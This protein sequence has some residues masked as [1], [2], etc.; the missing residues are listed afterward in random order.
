MGIKGRPVLVSDGIIS[1]DDRKHGGAATSVWLPAGEVYVTPAGGSAEGVIVADHLFYQGQ[2]I[3]GLKLEI[4]GGKMVS[5]TAKSGLESLKSLYDAAGEGKDLVGVI[6]L[7]INS[8]IHVPE[9]SPVNVW[10]R[11][12][13]VTV[14]VGNNTWAGGDNKSA[15]AVF[16]EVPKATL[17]VDGI[18]IVKDGKLIAPATV[19]QH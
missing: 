14:G 8:N 17:T 16:P 4:K 7:G 9:G 3:D 2:R 18:E 13:A 10:S 6:D 19:A 12:G 15:F 1:A 5:M 11:A